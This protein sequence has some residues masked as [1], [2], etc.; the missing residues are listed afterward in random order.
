M[1]KKLNTV[2]VYVDDQPAAEKF[3][4]G[5]I[6]FVVKD[7]KAMGN[8]LYW[9][10]VAPP[11]AETALVIYPK[12]LMTNYAEL[13]PSIVFMCDDIVATCNDLRQKGVAFKD[14]LMDLPW[15]KFASFLDEDGNEF[16]LKG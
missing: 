8:G 12:A 15:G 7:K 3:W 10:E 11:N 2:G 6:N 1:I 5:K 16:G 14:E 13:K 4:T 9:L